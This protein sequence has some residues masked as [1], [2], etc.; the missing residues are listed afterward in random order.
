MSLIK[1]REKEKENKEAL[2]LDIDESVVAE[3]QEYL[4]WA[5]I[6]DKSHFIEEACKYVFQTDN[7][8][9]KFKKDHFEATGSHLIDKIETDFDVTNQMVGED[10]GMINLEDEHN[11]GNELQKKNK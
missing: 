3:L 10:E 4:K 2:H 6:E 11:L 5:K 8:W 1:N 7:D 9:K